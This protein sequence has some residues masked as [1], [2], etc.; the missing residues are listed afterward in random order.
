MSH[1]GAAAAAAVAAAPPPPRCPFAH[2]TVGVGPY[3]G[4]VHGAHPAICPAGCVPDARVLRDGAT[5]ARGARAAAT[6]HALG[7][8]RPRGYMHD[9]VAAPR[10]WA[11]TRLLPACVAW[12]RRA[13]E[14][15]RDTLLREALD[16]AALFAAET[17]ASAEAAASRHD[18]ICASVAATGT[19]VH[20]LPELTHGA[21]VAWRNAPKCANRRHWEELQ[22][23]DARGARTAADMYDACLSLLERAI[24]STAAIASICVF[25]PQTPGTADGPRVWNSQLLR[26]AG[27]RGG[28]DK[29]DEGVL[30][31]PSELG[32]SQMLETEFG[33]VPPASRS[34]FDL[35]PLL[36][37]ARPEEE[38]VLFS[39]PRQ[40]GPTV[41][42]SHPSH[43]WFAQ[44]NL[45]WYAIPV[46]AA[47]DLSIGGLTYTAAPFNGWYAS[48]EVVRNLTDAGR[49]DVSRAVAARLGLDTRAEAS[50]WRDAALATVGV[51]VLHSY[52]KAGFAM[53][54]HHTL[55]AAFMAWYPAELKARGY[56][57]GNWKWIVPPMAASATEAYLGLSRMTEYT[58][59]PAYLPGPGWGRLRRAWLDS[60]AAQGSASAARVAARAA[61][62][63]AGS[64]SGSGV[65]ALAAVGRA[66]RAF[67]ARCS[68]SAARPRVLLAFATVGGATRAAALEAHAALRGELSI[69]LRDLAAM[70]TPAAFAAELAS[71]DLLL[72]LSSTVNSGEAPASAAPLLAW[73]A[74]EAGAGRTPLRGARF[75]VL[76]LGSSAY[77]RF[78]AAGHALHAALCAAGGAPLL[79]G[80]AAVDALA[81]PE[82]ARHAWLAAT[83]A[84]AADAGCVPAAT[85]ARLAAR[86]SPDADADAA[87]AT[88]PFALVRLAGC[89]AAAQAPGVLSATVTRN[90]PIGTGASAAHLTLALPPG[91]GSEYDAGD[92]LAVW[93]RNSDADV[94][95]VA[96][97]LRLASSDDDAMYEYE[98]FE[99][100]PRASPG[101]ADAPPPPPPFPTPAT[102]RGALGGEVALA[103]A[104]S[105]GALR[106]LRRYLAGTGAG[107]AADALAPACASFDAHAAAVLAAGV[108]WASLFAAF[109]PLRGAVT[110][111]AFFAVVPAIRPRYY[112][113]ASAPAQRS[114]AGG[115]GDARPPT[116]QLVVSRLR[117]THAAT[118]APATG[119]A[120]GWLHAA[121]PGAAV[122][123]ALV[124]APAFRLPL[125][126]AAP[127]VLI[128]AGAGVA[129]LRAMWQ[130]RAARIDAAGAAADAPAA[131]P[132]AECFLLFGC[133][134]E[135]DAW[136][137]ADEMR[138]AQRAGTLRLRLA[139]SRPPPGAAD[140]PPPRYVQHLLRDVAA[141]DAPLH[142]ALTHPRA[143]VLVCGGV[144]MADAVCCALADALG[145]DAFSAMRAQ[146]RL[147]QDVFGAKPAA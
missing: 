106:A 144:A 88:P 56:C 90:V 33:W 27:Y 112:S 108:T 140:A 129:P 113:I 122:R 124:R 47:M 132:A 22:V 18:E 57:P 17:G 80:A 9:C 105:L 109:P 53:V 25:R 13:G 21:R 127:V 147:R 94:A 82:R 145:A 63:G 116:L 125:A 136:L 35:L 19:Y 30:G 20:T 45:R 72:A 107:A 98:F 41:P 99:L 95:A 87:P 139:L 69:T 135:G 61:A 120:S 104:P 103:D 73:L 23:M 114:H 59:K 74:A 15:P 26:F 37:Q 84:A 142:A 81:A 7:I 96:A 32:F 51:A 66:A 10:S 58:L 110:P 91:G 29:G 134:D 2:G 24:E 40:Y 102:L 67:T 60:G 89:L 93:A 49:Y 131:A 85:A 100:R 16:F 31:D 86:L 77:P 123:C 118:G 48:T 71:H 52:A 76:A 68:A 128:G 141:A 28:G 79:P 34:A 64:G 138:A 137:F 78:C 54:D 111:E 70:P 8:C 130:E 5:G 119:F 115:A 1:E 101:A 83:L 75:S 146:G 44:L 133:R 12:P 4:Y 6:L 65:A 36:L 14:S 143:V 3:P 126:A 43:D 50:L 11:L 38:P 117:Y 92:E 55:A 39:L 62:R 42:L 121:A 97:G 46:V